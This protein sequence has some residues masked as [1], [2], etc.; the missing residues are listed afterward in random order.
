MES[1]HHNSP[2]IK[3]VTPIA[4]PSK[5]VISS[6]EAKVLFTIQLADTACII[7]QRLGE[8]CGHGPILEQDIAVTNL[9]LDHIGQAR[10]WY[11][12]AAV[13][14]QK[15]PTATDLFQSQMFLNQIQNKEIVSEDDLAFLRD[16]WD[17]KNPLLV[18][19]PNGNW[20]TT[21]ARNFFLDTYQYFL[22]QQLT[23]SEDEQWRAIAEKSLKEVSYH[24]RWSS[25]WMIR[26]GD[27]TDESHLKI[28]EAVNQLWEFTG[29]LFKV[30]EVEEKAGLS[31][32]I[33]KI[34]SLWLERI[35]TIFSEA[36][37][38]MPT[39]QWMQEGGKQGIHSEHLGYILSEMQF[40]QRTYPNQNW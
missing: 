38:E 37:L 16:A 15:L 22:Y 19:Q 5:R 24:L 28:Q 1:T 2:Q 7:G 6:D 4:P 32:I 39:N 20:A 29:E 17:F 14:L 31:S 10:S 40:M 9:A 3:A 26:L 33:N 25:E 36:T 11:Q 23:E 8:W 27:G 35:Q 21:I 30:S 34:H 13:L 18:E 12:Y